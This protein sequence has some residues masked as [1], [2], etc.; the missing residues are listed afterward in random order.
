MCSVSP[1]CVL[2]YHLCLCICHLKPMWLNSLLHP[3][4]TPECKPDLH[5]VNRILH[6]L[7]MNQNIDITSCIWNCIIT[8]Y[9]LDILCLISNSCQFTEKQINTNNR[10]TYFHIILILVAHSRATGISLSVCV[11]FLQYAF[12]DTICVYAF[13][14]W[15][16][17][18]IF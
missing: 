14:I 13:V 16:I 6:K 15:N 3:L 11:H 1:I 10:A 5:I 17:N 18:N 4:Q 9:M 12:S 8:H 7:Y 2:W